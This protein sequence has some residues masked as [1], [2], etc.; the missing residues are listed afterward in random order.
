MDVTGFVVYKSAKGFSL[1]RQVIYDETN[2]SRGIVWK[3]VIFKVNQ[4]PLSYLLQASG[5]QCSVGSLMY[6]KKKRNR[7]VYVNGL[8]VVTQLGRIQQAA[9][10]YNSSNG[11]DVVD[12]FIK[13]VQSVREEM[14]ADAKKLVAAGEIVFDALWYLFEKGTPI[15]YIDP[16][17]DCTFGTIVTNWNYSRGL[18][19]SFAINGPIMKSDGQHFYQEPVS[20]SIPEFSGIV[21]IDT[22]PVQPLSRATH[23]ALTARGKI[24]SEIAIGAHFKDYSSVLMTPSLFGY[25]KFK[26]NGRVMIDVSTYNRMNPNDRKFVSPELQLTG[27]HVGVATLTLKPSQYWMTYPTLPGFSF[28]LKKWGEFLVE[29]TSDIEFDDLSFVQLVLPKDKKKMIKALVEEHQRSGSAHSKRSTKVNKDKNTE[30]PTPDI[31]DMHQQADLIKYKGGGCIF[32]LHGSPGVGKTLTAEAVSEHLHIP[33][34]QVTVG[35]LG[36]KPDQLEKNLANLL[37]LAALW[38]CSILLDEAD[39]FLERRSK[40]DILRNAM[41]GIF[42]RLLEYHQGVLFLTTNRVNCLDD[43]FSSRISVSLYYPVLDESARAQIWKNFLLA[44][45]HSSV[46]KSKSKKSFSRHPEEF[47]WKKL[48]SY[49]INGRQIRS[50]VRMARALANSEGKVL[51]QAHLIQT[52][53]LSLDFSQQF[54]TDSKK[55]QISRA[56]EQ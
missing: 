53:Q 23:T 25:M 18:S 28:M 17:T 41:V 14:L 33:L 36:T 45:S 29:A 27:K 32:L 15:S 5:I 46:K 7:K 22:M 40:N 54:E 9:M 1:R 16:T 8:Q 12:A 11:G 34:Y 55:S 4:N 51:S 37:E 13:T 47:D 38:N 30:T 10:N 35:E 52:I 31:N 19:V 26:A 50:C 2:P 21:K 39:I 49:E 48:S 56:E 44:S 24:F 43:A 3:N 42:L 20:T 6:K